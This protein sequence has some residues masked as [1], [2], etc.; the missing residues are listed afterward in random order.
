MAVDDLLGGSL[1]GE[2]L[3]SLG[4]RR[5]AYLGSVVDTTPVARRR[6]G[7]RQT[8]ADVGLDP[9]EALLDV[10]I[11]VNPS[12]A[13]SADA[14]RRILT[15]VPRPTAVVCLNDTAALAVLRELEVAG[16]RVPANM[17]VVGYDDL[18]FTA[19][20]SPP[21]TTVAQPTYRLGYAAA[22]LLLDEARTDHTHREIL[23]QPSLV[24]RSSTAAPPTD[25]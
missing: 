19:L 3:L 11:P 23:F 15:A 21:L 10:R 22:D 24:V 25:R 14:V 12:L 8:L 2:H 17:S 4:H 5:I 16:V 1:A 20:L 13:D 7:V 18:P 6:A 9:D